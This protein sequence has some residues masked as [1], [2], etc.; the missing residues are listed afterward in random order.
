MFILF[1][2]KVIIKS[3]NV[4]PQS[5]K[6]THLLFC[7]TRVSQSPITNIYRTWSHWRFTQ[8][9]LWWFCAFGAK[10]LSWSWITQ[11]AFEFPYLRLSRLWYYLWEYRWTLSLQ[12]HSNGCWRKYPI[13]TRRL[14]IHSIAFKSHCWTDWNSTYGKTKTFNRLRRPNQLYK[15]FL[16]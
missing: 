10:T 4:Q 15:R 14:C 11:R 1:Q 2:P 7:R 16:H 12:R 8:C 3:P 13:G 6:P 5:Y 9:S